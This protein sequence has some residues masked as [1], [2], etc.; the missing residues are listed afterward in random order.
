MKKMKRMKRML[1]ITVAMCLFLGVS[2]ISVPAASVPVKDWDELLEPVYLMDFSPEDGVFYDSPEGTPG[3][4]EVAREDNPEE[5]TF[6]PGH[7]N[8]DDKI[9][10]TE[11]DGNNSRVTANVGNEN[12]YAAFSKGSEENDINT[13]SSGAVDDH[14]LKLMNPGGVDGG[15]PPVVKIELP[16]TYGGPDDSYR[17]YRVEFDWKWQSYN[18]LGEPISSQSPTG[19][20]F[21]SFHIGGQ[22]LNFYGKPSS[23]TD[24]RGSGA[25]CFWDAFGM[26][27]TNQNTTEE[28]AG[29]ISKTAQ[30]LPASSSGNWVHITVDFDFMYGTINAVIEGV[31]ARREISTKIESGFGNFAQGLSA[32]EVRGSHVTDLRA[33]L[34]DN[35]KLTPIDGPAFALSPGEVLGNSAYSMDFSPVDGVFYDSP[36]GTPGRMAVV[37]EDNP[38][39]ITFF[40]GHTSVDNKIVSTAAN[41]NNS[42]ITANTSTI[43][44]FIAFSKGEA[45]GDVNTGASGAVDDYCIKAIDT[46]T[47]TEPYINIDFPNNYGSSSDIQKKYRFEMDWRV[48]MYS[49]ETTPS[50][51]GRPTGINLINFNIGGQTLYLMTRG[52]NENIIYL[53]NAFGM[54]LAN[55]TGS[56]RN[57]MPSATDFNNWMHIT[58]DFDFELGTIDVD[59]YGASGRSY[60]FSTNI[61]GGET[62]FAQG[63]SG[64]SL[65][66]ST[67]TNRRAIWA[68]NVTMTPIMTKEPVAETKGVTITWP[69]VAGVEAY[70]V[71]QGASANEAMESTTP[72][73]ALVFDSIK[74]QGYV[75]TTL[76]GLEIGVPYYFAVTAVSSNKGESKKSNIVEINITQD[77]VSDIEFE[78]TDVEGETAS[79]RAWVNITAVEDFENDVILIASVHDGDRMTNVNLSQPVT[80]SHGFNPPIEVTLGNLSITPS[81]NVKIKF[82]LWDE[83][84]RPLNAAEFSAQEFE[85]MV[86]DYLNSDN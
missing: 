51:T 47:G 34:A 7:T 55:Q 31:G 72:L 57:S 73:E 39:G 60:S 27:L 36:E 5:I 53:A 32:I 86:D 10:S 82:F 74:K 4:M 2:A 43:N 70:N 33:V 68:D 69:A 83:N 41:G 54:T 37:R 84:L 81:S 59:M 71:Y 3:R 48:Q 16:T 85:G 64:V 52:S 76:S 1:C 50:T 19:G 12:Y 28:E 75:S 65:R 20:Y 56:K 13:G 11:A 62:D 77:I 15:T 80:I 44:E 9:I 42:R 40:P 67:T 46:G 58:V 30:R 66:S 78:V 25:L 29:G 6:F 18:S 22:V 38:E 26:N 8:A 79:G 49:D 24:A 63:L 21:F 17:K 14:A 61:E 35:I 23:T 45:E